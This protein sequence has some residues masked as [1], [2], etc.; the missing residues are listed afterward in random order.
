M[1][2]WLLWYHA[3]WHPDPHGAGGLRTSAQD[4]T[5]RTTGPWYSIPGTRIFI[6]YMCIWLHHWWIQLSGIAL[7]LFK[8]RR[9]SWFGGSS[10]LAGLHNSQDWQGYGLARRIKRTIRVRPT[11]LAWHARSVHWMYLQDNQ[12]HSIQTSRRQSKNQ[13]HATTYLISITKHGMIKIN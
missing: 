8:W 6:K 3:L 4:N 12:I 11:K 13:A 1:P 9:K 10:T 7:R 2:A 5:W